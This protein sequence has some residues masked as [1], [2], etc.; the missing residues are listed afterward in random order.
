MVC[1]P[2]YFD[3]IRQGLDCSATIGVGADV[4]AACSQNDRKAALN[5]MIHG[6]MPISTQCTSGSLKAWTIQGFAWVRQVKRRK[7]LIDGI[8][9]QARAQLWSPSCTDSPI[10]YQAALQAMFPKIQG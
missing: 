8:A 9:V 10:L 1:N 2:V 6:Q 4:V 7:A 3:C 5:P